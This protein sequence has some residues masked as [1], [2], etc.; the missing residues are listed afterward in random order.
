MLLALGIQGGCNKR[1]KGTI[2]NT[3][4]RL[5]PNTPYCYHAG[6]AAPLGFTPATGHRNIV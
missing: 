4:E 6:H 2:P 5:L 3:L 1:D